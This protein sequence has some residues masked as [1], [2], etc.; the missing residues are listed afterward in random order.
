MK[1][2]AYEDFLDI[3]RIRDIPARGWLA[4]AVRVFKQIGS[5]NVTIIAGGIAFF[6][7]LSVFPA[8]SAAVAIYSFFQ[9]PASIQDHLAIVQP[10]LPE[11]AFLTIEEIL[12]LRIE[13][14]TNGLGLSAI[15]SILFAIWSAKKGTN[16]VFRGV[17]V[18]YD[19]EQKRSFLLNTLLTVGFTL[20]G[21]LLLIVAVFLLAL[22]PLIIELT[23][24]D[25]SGALIASI[26][27]WLVMIIAVLSVLAIVYRI[28]PSR[29]IPRFRWV[30]PGSLFAC[31][32][33]LLGS[34]AFAWYSENLG[35][36][37][38]TYG[39]FTAVAVL[40]LWFYLSGIIILV[41]A[42]L[43]AEVE[44]FVKGGISRGT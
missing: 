23:G 28:A 38:K 27:R 8:L 37:S 21:L 31:F 24:L 36:Y 17:N 18:A 1:H 9:D 20:G 34:V 41:G 39:S 30:T 6:F 7:F 4:I 15:A 32:I 25:P 14:Q 22:F 5:D 13:N 44:R 43:N 33:W 42:E 40:L 11:E 35:D 3:A 16:A 19:I 2:E 10:L 29:K 12:T 26:I